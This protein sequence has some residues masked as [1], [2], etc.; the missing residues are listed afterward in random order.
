MPQQR[1]PRIVGSTAALAEGN[2]VSSSNGSE[3]DWCLIGYHGR[4]PGTDFRGM[5]VLGLKQLQFFASN[6]NSA[7]C[8]VLKIS[9]HER[10]YFPFAATGIN[11]TSLC[12]ELLRETRLH[13][14]LLEN[15]VAGYAD[16]NGAG[17]LGA[18][19]GAYGMRDLSG[20]GDPE[21]DEKA[22]LLG[23]QTVGSSYGAVGSAATNTTSDTDDTTG[24]SAIGA[25]SEC[26]S[27]CYA[28]FNNLYCTIYAD[29]ADFWVERDP[30]D[31]MQ[32]PKLFQE[33]REKLKMKYATI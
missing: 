7:A 25:N 6:R 19:G 13:R 1:L 17:G 27:R 33:F 23:P 11:I 16:T 29:W 8:R 3:V 20:L 4:D 15:L 31:I 14:L 21:G 30:R 32:F 18:G 22:H 10:R 12:L 26:L 9:N 2:G 5:G 28:S 24:P